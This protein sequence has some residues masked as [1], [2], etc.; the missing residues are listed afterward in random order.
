MTKLAK[1][2]SLIGVGSGENLP[3]LKLEI[4]EQNERSDHGE[5]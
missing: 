1:K 3:M 5:D 2:K 4:R